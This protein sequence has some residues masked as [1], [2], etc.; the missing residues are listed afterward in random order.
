VVEEEEAA[1]WESKVEVEEAEAKSAH[2][3]WAAERSA[4]RDECFSE[5]VAM[6]SFQCAES[7]I[8]AACDRSVV[9]LSIITASPS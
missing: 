2:R 5:S 9:Q 6:T 3:D 1:K 8:S 4:A 7:V